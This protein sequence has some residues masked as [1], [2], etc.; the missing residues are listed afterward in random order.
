MVL[1]FYGSEE[2]A[3]SQDRVK[4]LGGSVPAEIRVYHWPPNN[5]PKTGKGKMGYLH[6][7]CAVADGK[8]AFVSSANLTTYAMEMNME[9]GVLIDGGAVPSQI[10]DHFQLLIVD[11]V[12]QEWN[13]DE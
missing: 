8:K 12:L 6:V 9:L 10:A 7:K 1:E 2:G 5:R 3:S 13:P 11:G 4:A